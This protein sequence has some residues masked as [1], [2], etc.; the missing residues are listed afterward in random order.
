VEKA[1]EI[2]TLKGHSGN[3]KV[4][5]F[6]SLLKN[7]IPNCPSHN[8]KSGKLFAAP[9]GMPEIVSTSLHACSTIE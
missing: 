1:K 7:H 5:F 2:S 3:K 6:I 8:N 9:E 4:L